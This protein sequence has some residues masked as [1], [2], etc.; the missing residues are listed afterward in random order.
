MKAIIIL[1]G[2]LS[3]GLT[4]M[5]HANTISLKNSAKSIGPITV[6]YSKAYQNAGQS[7]HFGPEQ[8][9]KLKPGQSLQ[10]QNVSGL[11]VKKLTFITANGKAM[12]KSFNPADYGKVQSCSLATS[13]QVQLCLGKHRLTCQHSKL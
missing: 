1:L 5:A 11:L 13:G 2:V 4:G 12:S 6:T 3:M 10:T 7:S 9:L 8:Q